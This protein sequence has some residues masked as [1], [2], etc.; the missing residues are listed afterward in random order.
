L[1]CRN[2]VHS[3]ARIKENGTIKKEKWEDTVL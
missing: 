2:A 1:L 3:L